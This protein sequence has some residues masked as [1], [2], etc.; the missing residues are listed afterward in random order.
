MNDV[1][2]ILAAAAAG[3]PGTADQLLPLVYDELRRLAAHRMAR[4]PGGQTLDATALVHE[5]YLRLAAADPERRGGG[6][7]ALLP[8]APPAEGRPPGGTARPKGAPQ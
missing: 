1:P 6:P 3:V 4:E 7:R 2:P 5:A 8:P